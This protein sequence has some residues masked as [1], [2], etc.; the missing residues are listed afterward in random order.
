[1]SAHRIM[2]DDTGDLR[3]HGAAVTEV[4]AVDA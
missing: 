3:C 2:V 1:M 4:V